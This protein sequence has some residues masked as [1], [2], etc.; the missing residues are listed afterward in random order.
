MMIQHHPDQFLLNDYAAACLPGAVALTV[1]VHLDYC[2]RCREEVVQLN[3]LGGELFGSLDP[4]PVA[5]DALARLLS[6]LDAE[7]PAPQ[8]AAALIPGGAGGV[9]KLPRV[10]Q[11]LVPAGIEQLEWERSGRGIRTSRLRFGDPRREVA[12][13]HIR[14]GHRVPEHGHRGSEITVVLNGAFSDHE[15]CYREG[16]FLLR[17]ESDVHQPAVLPEADCLCLG[18]LE[19]PIRLSGLIGRLANPFLRLQPR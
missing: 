8:A 15:G 2:S 14:A 1:A 4:V 17:V 6:S 18:V 12:L 7:V 19:A 9:R 3:H 13:Y 11:W 5:V 10:L 16:D